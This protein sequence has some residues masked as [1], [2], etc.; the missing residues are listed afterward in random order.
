MASS[1]HDG[2]DQDLVEACRLLNIKTYEPHKPPVRKAAIV[3]GRPC[4]VRTEKTLDQSISCGARPDGGPISLQVFANEAARQAQ[5]RLC[6]G[7]VE[8]R[9]MDGFR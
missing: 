3:D 4:L 2:V 9:C 7:E 6:K 5:I 8:A 1:K